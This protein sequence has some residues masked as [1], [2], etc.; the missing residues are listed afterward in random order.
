MANYTDC[1]PLATAKWLELFD[2]IPYKYV[3]KLLEK[4]IDEDE[5]ELQV[6]IEDL[7]PFGNRCKTSFTFTL[8]INVS[9][10]C[11]PIMVKKAFTI[12]KEYHNSS[13]MALMI[14]ELQYPDEDEED[15]SDE[16]VGCVCKICEGE[17]KTFVSKERAK[18][19]KENNELEECCPFDKCNGEETDDEL[20]FE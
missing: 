4:N 11:L 6:E 12:T 19:L 3:K 10:G 14:M 1:I 8:D 5:Y 15:E 18:E 2:D 17:G 20:E 16:E 13:P 9:G 7:P